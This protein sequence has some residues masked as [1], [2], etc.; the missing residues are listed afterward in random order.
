MLYGIK[1]TAVFWVV[2]FVLEEYEGEESNGFKAKKELYRLSVQSDAERSAVL[3]HVAPNGHST[4]RDGAG[5]AL[6][7]RRCS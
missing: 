4:R 1:T 5:R 3:L 2:L 7:A 6:F